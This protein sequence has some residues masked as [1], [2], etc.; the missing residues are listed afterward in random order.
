MF[1]MAIRRMYK[2]QRKLTFDCLV[3][4]IEAIKVFLFFLYD[5]ASDHMIML[6]VVFLM[7]TTIRA[8]VCANFF[9][10][11]LVI[12]KR[13]SWKKPFTVIYYGLIIGAMVTILLLSLVS[14]QPIN[15]KT[16]VFSYH[17]FLIDTVDLAQSILIIVSSIFI[18]KYMQQNMLEQ[19]I[20]FATISHEMKSQSSLQKQT[21]L[22]AASYFNFVFIDFLMM[23]IGNYSLF[24]DEDFTCTSDS[25][26][27]VIS[28]GSAIFFFVYSLL[29]LAFSFMMWVIFYKIP[30][31][32][33]LISKTKPDMYIGPDNT[34]LTIDSESIA[35]NIIQI[36]REDDF[37]A[38]SPMMSDEFGRKQRM[39]LRINNS[40]K[41]SVTIYDSQ[42][43]LINCRPAKQ[44]KQQYQQI[45][46]IQ[47]FQ[48]QSLIYGCEGQE[49]VDE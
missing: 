2:T 7:Q 30:D 23:S 10:K 27:Q 48:R 41:N 12:S 19:T 4:G 16:L 1:G 17:W 38:S 25:Y 40:L 39:R 5:F 28:D 31:H 45:R 18:V 26:I 8:I 9:Q 14:E 47:Y 36:S 20:S 6:L 44:Y 34:R 33:G 49:K 42:N 15:C 24:I 13:K 22:L 43:L 46:G 21:K 35:E 32:Y 37:I 29:L 11:S 3:L